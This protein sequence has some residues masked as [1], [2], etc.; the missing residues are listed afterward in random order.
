MVSFDV[1]KGDSIIYNMFY[2]QPNGTALN[3]TG[4]T[5]KING[6]S[7]IREESIISVSNEDIT[8]NIRMELT[9]LS[10]G[11]FSLIIQDSSSFEIGTYLIDIS[12][13]TPLGYTHS[14]RSFKL[15]IKK[16]L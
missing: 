6:V 13:L 2:K 3:L 12:F 1:K 8:G 11:K 9:D 14:T 16:R 5:I 4:F 7:Y 15:N 10:T